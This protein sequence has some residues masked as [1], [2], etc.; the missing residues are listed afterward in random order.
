MFICSF[1]LRDITAIIMLM[2]TLVKPESI[3]QLLTNQLR[4]VKINLF[5]KFKVVYLSDTS[6]YVPVTSLRGRPGVSI[7]PSAPYHTA[8]DL[9][10]WRPDRDWD[11]DYTHRHRFNS[12]RVQR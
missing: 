7:P 10:T 2:R 1:M 11:R 3:D 9:E 6:G 12:T 5:L 8:P 4:F